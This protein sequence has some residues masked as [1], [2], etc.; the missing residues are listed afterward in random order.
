MRP[1]LGVRLDKLSSLG[2]PGGFRD[3]LPCIDGTPNLI[4]V[5]GHLEMSKPVLNQPRAVNGCEDL[6][7][8]ISFTVQMLQSPSFPRV[9]TIDEAPG[10]QGFNTIKT[11]RT[12]VDRVLE[13]RLLEHAYLRAKS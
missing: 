7:L 5:E 11:L 2:S 4:R 3:S 9:P 6:Y 1:D 12:R 8:N 10:N 13:S